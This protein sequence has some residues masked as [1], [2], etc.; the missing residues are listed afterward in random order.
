MREQRNALRRLLRRSPSLKR[1][2]EATITEVYADALGRASDET[3]FSRSTFPDQLP[4]SVAQVLE[5]EVDPSLP[6]AVRRQRHR[7]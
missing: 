3:G 6:P 7:R 5:P 2:L 4:Y 1:G